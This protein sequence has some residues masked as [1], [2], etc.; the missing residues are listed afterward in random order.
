MPSHVLIPL[1]LFKEVFSS[2]QVQSG[3]VTGILK[4][5]GDKKLI[6]GPLTKADDAKSTKIRKTSNAG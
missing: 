1:T 5:K 3:F 2:V 4:R 6:S